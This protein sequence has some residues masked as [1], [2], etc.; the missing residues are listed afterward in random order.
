MAFMPVLLKKQKQVIRLQE[1]F[2]PIVE[3]FKSCDY[4]KDQHSAV[5]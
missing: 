5:M 3:E 1:G 4:A 2:H